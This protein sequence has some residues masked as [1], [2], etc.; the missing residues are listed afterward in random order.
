MKGKES[1][2]GCLEI[3]VFRVCN[4]ATVIIN[5]VL[6]IKILQTVSDDKL[7]ITSTTLSEKSPSLAIID[8]KVKK[9]K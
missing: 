8:K 7:H 4:I 6:S 5:K 3:N 2:T 9:K 1:C